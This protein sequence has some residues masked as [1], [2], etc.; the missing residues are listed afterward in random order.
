MDE[1]QVLFPLKGTINSLLY[2][3]EVLYNNNQWVDFK[4]Y[5]RLMGA[6]LNI[7]DSIIIILEIHPFIFVY[8][9][10]ILTCYDRE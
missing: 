8:Y 6:I 10:L 1:F 3:P 9:G 4:C 7:P 5:F 2:T